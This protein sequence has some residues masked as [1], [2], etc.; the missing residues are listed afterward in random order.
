MSSSQFSSMTVEFQKRK[1]TWRPQDFKPWSPIAERHSTSLNFSGWLDPGAFRWC[2]NWKTSQKWEDCPMMPNDS[3][4]PCRWT[5][6]GPC[7]WC[8]E[9]ACLLIARSK[10]RLLAYKASNVPKHPVLRRW[11]LENVTDLNLIQE[12]APELEDW[13]ELDLFG[14]FEY[15]YS[16]DTTLLLKDTA[17]SLEPDEVHEIFN[18]LPGVN[19]KKKASH[20]LKTSRRST[21]GEDWLK[22]ILEEISIGN[23]SWFD[24]VVG[25]KPKEREL[26]EVA[27]LY[28]MLT[29]KAR[30]YFVSTEANLASGIFKYLDSQAMLESENELIA[31]C[32]ERFIAFHM[33]VHNPW[34][35]QVELSYDK[36]EHEEGL[37]KL[38]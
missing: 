25:L 22:E 19:E 1:L 14:V 12:G 32:Q 37:W 18:Y 5:G 29:L 2:Q 16:T 31:C 13:A 10:A 7:R 4:D 21:R 15:D 26:N 34:F 17:L 6:Y 23:L 35:L 20:E 28:G 24:H 30:L 11:I 3:S 27:R 33:R 9:E 36:T 38:G 8:S